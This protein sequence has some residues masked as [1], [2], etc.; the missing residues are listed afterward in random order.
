MFRL[1]SLFFILVV[2]IH[3]LS[4]SAI[5]KRADGFMKTSNKSNQFRAYNDYKN[6]YLRSIMAEDNKLK[7]SALEN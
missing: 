2:S 4:D 6:L 7:I 1:F 3:A 5:L